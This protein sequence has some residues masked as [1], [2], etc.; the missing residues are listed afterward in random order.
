NHD[1]LAVGYGKLD[2]LEA[3]GPGLV[4]IWSIRNPEHPERVINTRDPVT[5]L[6]FSVRSPNILAV[7]MYSGVVNVYDIRREGDTPIESSHNMAGAHNDPV[8][9]VSWRTQGAERS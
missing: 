7:G 8:W 1:I 2:F 9:Q 3:D 4:L 5:S 6:D